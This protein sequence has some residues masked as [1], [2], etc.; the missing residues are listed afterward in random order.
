M[1]SASVPLRPRAAVRHHSLSRRTAVSCSS[2]RD[3]LFGELST[4]IDVISQLPPSQRRAGAEEAAAKCMT[5]LRQLQAAGELRT[6]DSYAGRLLRRPISMGELKQM[7][8]KAP[9]AIGR[10]SV[11]NDAAF[12]ASVVGGSSVVAVVLGVTLP[13]DWGAFGAYLSGGVSLVVLAIGSVAPGLLEVPIAAFSGLFPDYRER[14]L[15]HEAAHFLIAHLLGV[16]V[17]QYS[18]A[19]GAEH[20]DLLEAKLERKLFGATAQRLTDAEL[21][22]LAV[23]AMSGVASEGLR[24]EE[25]IGQNADLYDLQKLINRSATSLSANQQ[26]SLTRWAVWQAAAMLKGNA[27]AYAALQ[28]A[29]ARGAPVVDCIRAIESF[30]PAAA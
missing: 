16:P 17:V 15:R 25:V 3:A 2:S 22:T 23:V 29:M 1:L 10:P 28:E 12:L 5:L 6:F 9:D 21:D 27:G 7:G 4:S 24:F 13:G 8:I 11:R 19:L 18:L 14:V 20:T 26:Q 30:Q